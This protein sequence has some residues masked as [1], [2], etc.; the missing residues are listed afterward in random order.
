MPS[1]E[2]DWLEITRSAL[3]IPKGYSWDGCSPKIKFY[4]NFIGTPDFGDK[5]HDASLVHDALYQYAG[6]HGLTRRRCDDIF[7]HLME[8][9]NFKLA[10]VYYYA[11]RTFGW[12]FWKR[13]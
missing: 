11:V 12:L 6:K 8:K 5:T 3:I 9:N 13:K 1:F 10:K 7:L 4:G 2:A